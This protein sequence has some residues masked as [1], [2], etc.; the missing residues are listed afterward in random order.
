[1]KTDYKFWYITRD[2]DV[3]ISEAG[4]IFREGETYEVDGIEM[5]NVNKK[6]K[7]E[8]LKHIK[9]AKTRTMIDGTEAIVFIK[10]DFGEIKTDD[11]FRAFVNS[12]LIKDKDREAIDVQSITDVKVLKTKKKK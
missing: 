1:M 7:K 4:V 10:E 8:D 11:E 12:I 2:D 6:L 9:K 5:F 3:F